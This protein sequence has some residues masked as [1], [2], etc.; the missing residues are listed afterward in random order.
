MTAAAFGRAAAL[1]LLA[2]GAARAGEGAAPA[3]RERAAEPAATA[4]S[5]PAS[6]PERPRVAAGVLSR[7]ASRRAQKRD[8]AAPREGT[9]AG[10]PHGDGNIESI[11][12]DWNGPGSTP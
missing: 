8:A 12:I 4:A 2:A 6:A 10:A 9:D 11:E 5:A 7:A 3:A 1:A